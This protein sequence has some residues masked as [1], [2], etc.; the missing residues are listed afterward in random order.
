[1]V[2]KVYGRKRYL[3]SEILFQYEYM[4]ES[5]RKPL[6]HN[7]EQRIRARI[8]KGHLPNKST[9]GADTFSKS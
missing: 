8:H 1:M 9:T 7:P 4:V 3:E 6:K 2:N 5:L